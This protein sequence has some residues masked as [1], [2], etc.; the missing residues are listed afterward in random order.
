MVL[1][2]L[3]MPSLKKMNSQMSAGLIVLHVV[4]C[5]LLMNAGKLFPSFVYRD[6]TNLRTRIALSIGMMPRG[7]VC[8][9]IIVNAQMLGASGP[10][11]TIAIL[12]LGLRAMKIASS[13][14][15]RA[16]CRNCVAQP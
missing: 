1:V 15:C 3:S 16:S 14:G 6:E 11:I 13:R 10:G 7:E 2:G 8:A 5:S 4:I 12:C 9:G